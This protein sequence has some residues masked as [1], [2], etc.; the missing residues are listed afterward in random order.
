MKQFILMSMVLLFFSCS[1]K[2][3]LPMRIS[4][5]LKTMSL[6]P[7][8]MEDI[9][10]MMVNFQIHSSLFQYLPDGSIVSDIAND[11]IISDDFLTYTFSLSTKYF[12]DQSQIT[13][14]DVEKS[15][16]RIFVKGASISADLQAIDGYAQFLKNND[17]NV[18][19]IKATKENKLV[20][21][22][23]K[24]NP[25][26]IK[27]LATPDTAILKLNESLDLVKNIYSGKYRVSKYEAN[28]LELTLWSKDQYTSKN[29]ARDVKYLLN[30]KDD[31]YNLAQKNEIDLVNLS[32]LN[33]EQIELIKSLKFKEVVSGITHEQ[34][35]VLNPKLISLDWRKYLMF[36]FNTEE[37]IKEIGFNNLEPAYG[38]V[39]TVLKGSIKKSIKD[40]IDLTFDNSK[41][42]P[43]TLTINLTT[44][45]MNERIATVLKK[46][47]SHSNL[48]LSFNFMKIDSY[49]ESIFA[50]KF[51]A[52][53]VPKG[54]DYPDA[55]ANLSYFKSDI[56]DNFFLVFDK[57]IDKKIEL[58]ST[59]MDKNAEC[60][61]DLQKTIMQKV[62]VIPLFFGTDKIEFWSNNIKSVPPHPLG[63]QFLKLD[64]IE[65]NDE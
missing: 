25:I 7:H 23:S 56:K 34:F 51:E 3:V 41:L 26:L 37:L 45:K 33:P 18:L 44:G 52:V 61:V 49:L 22:L 64:Q 10:S 54:L 12:S 38:F 35:L 42:T 13:A 29:A 27:Q 4:L 5:P 48:K 57:E 40:Q 19:G 62:N 21:K 39:P 63:I 20:I 9:Y 17:Q 65:M 14:A 2:E 59:T 11:Y 8:H 53:I 58:C 30:D 28:L 43:I 46:F 31:S 24:P 50:K 47:W 32:L 16:K 55:M 36:Q 60:F 15:L 6:D 1:K